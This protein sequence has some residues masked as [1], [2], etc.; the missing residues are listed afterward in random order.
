MGY[1]VNAL[2]IVASNDVTVSSG[3]LSLARSL[4]VT[5]SSTFNANGNFTLLST[6][7]LKI[8]ILVFTDGLAH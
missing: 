5:G 6:F 2:D 8:K 7:Y 4:E 3:M 1:G